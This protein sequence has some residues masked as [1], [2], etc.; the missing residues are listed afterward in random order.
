MK[1]D[2][3]VFNELLKAEKYE[4]VD[5]YL[6]DEDKNKIPYHVYMCVI[7][8]ETLAAIIVKK[9]PINNEPYQIYEFNG[10]KLLD[11][12]IVRIKDLDSASPKFTK[13]INSFVNKEFKFEN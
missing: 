11:H 3:K 8:S 6:I 2:I 4:G 9:M 12:K 10:N 13:L 5:G 7:E 1:F